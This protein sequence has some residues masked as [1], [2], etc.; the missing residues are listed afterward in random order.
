M[1]P[2][3]FFDFHLFDLPF[4]LVLPSHHILI[5]LLFS[6]LLSYP[7]SFLSVP[8]TSVSL[9]SIFISFK[10]PFP[11]HHFRFLLFSSPLDAPFPLVPLSSYY[12]KL[13]SLYSFSFFHQSFPFPLLSLFLIS[14][15]S[16]PSPIWTFPLSF[17]TFHSQHNPFCNHK[18]SG[19]SILSPLPPPGWPHRCRCGGQ[20]VCGL[21]RSRRPS[22]WSSAW[23]RRVPQPCQSAHC[24]GSPWQPERKRRVRDGLS[25]CCYWRLLQAHFHQYV[26]VSP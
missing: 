8:I 18:W 24:S 17:P 16:F 1:S 13:S 7:S 20:T 19:F 22:W 4:P 6:S 11:S 2:L 12:I 14:L 3:F 5:Y 15:F 25:V 23:C 10:L 21:W 26:S 9:S